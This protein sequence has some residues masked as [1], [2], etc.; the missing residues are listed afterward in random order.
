[1]QFAL[2]PYRP[3]VAETNPAMSRRVINVSVYADS[4]GVSYGPRSSLQVTE[5]ATA[6]PAA[7]R[8]GL[9]V[10]TRAGVF[11]GFFGTAAELYELTSTYGFTAIGS[12]LYTLPAGHHWG[13]CQYGEN[14]IFTNTSDGMFSYDIE[15]P[16]GVNAV[17][18]APDA[19]FVFV[20]FECVFALDCDGDNRVMKN[21]APGSLS[22]WTTQGAGFQEFPD[23]EALMGGAAINEGTA[24][25]LQGAAVHLLQAVS[26][27]RVYT[28]RKISDEVGAVSP[29]CIVQAP[30]AVYFVSASG[31]M[32][33]SAGGLEFIGENKVARTFI[34]AV[35]DLT[36][37]E[38]AY[39]PGRRQV[40]WRY[41]ANGVGSEI[42]ENILVYDIATGEFVEVEEQTTALLKMSAAAQTLEDLDA[43][44][45][46]DSLPFSLDSSAWKGRSPRLFALDEARKGG[47]FD[48]DNYA[49]TVDTATLTNTRSMLFR[50]ASPV[51]DAANVTLN[52]GV[53]DR[54]ADALTYQGAVSMLE[55]GTVPLDGRGKCG[56]LTVEIPAG[57]DWHYLR[58]IDD[59]DVSLGGRR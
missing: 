25:V 38:G 56:V 8:G 47:F 51:T 21:S 50:W 52:L 19:R 17:T 5:T 31:P 41:Q 27:K 24:V 48:G 6:L 28:K 42:F 39:D 14:I 7:P 3:D 55:D 4:A 57:E 29:Q 13:M 26:D 44:G 11:K 20:A 12:G 59:L 10:V 30:G 43:F 46:L 32:R 23:G 15:T 40:A 18:D 35:D 34:E 45:D 33:V 37:V 16:A 2:G 53:K 49:A 58:G 1:M 22:N 9:A 36:S 54:L